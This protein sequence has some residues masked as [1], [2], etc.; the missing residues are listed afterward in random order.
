MKESAFFMHLFQYSL[1]PFYF[2]I[3]KML[4]TIAFIFILVSISVM[5]SAQNF[6]A[7]LLAGVCASQ[8]S[9]DQLA[10]FNKAGIMIGAGIN[11]LI[12]KKVSLGFEIY[13]IQKGSRKQNDVEKGDLEYY[14]LRLNYM[15]VPVFF[16]Y[17]LSDKFG[18]IAGPSVGTLVGS[19]EEDQDGE[20]IGQPPFIKYEVSACGGFK[21]LFSDNWGL[22]LRGSQSL[23]PV[24]N[25]SNRS[26][27]RLNRGQYNSVLM[28]TLFYQFD[29]KTKKNND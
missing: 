15:E 11:T 22:Y 20:I 25:H 27:Y 14:R 26:V 10:G 17:Q 16:Q 5:T 28:F 7:Q 21:Y 2:D 29:N 23:A 13:Y 18:I 12:A 8:V 1:P 4:K 24:R 6:N 19:E 9:G 3:C